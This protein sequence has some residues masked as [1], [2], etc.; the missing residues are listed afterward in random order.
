MQ[1]V[2]FRV[3]DLGCRV[4]GAEKNRLLNWLSSGWMRLCSYSPVTGL[5]SKKYLNGR[6]KSEIG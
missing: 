3:Q 1:G 4:Q 6:N 2:G 5:N